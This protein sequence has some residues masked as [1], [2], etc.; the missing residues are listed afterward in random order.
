MS[1]NPFDPSLS[2]EE[3]TELWEPKKEYIEKD[4]WVIRNFLTEQELV[5]LNNEANDP[6]G[7]Y[8]TMRSPYGG[9]IKNKFIGYIPEYDENGSLLVPNEK[10]KWKNRDIMSLIEKRIE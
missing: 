5:Y 1:K 8:T 10:S 6:E 2:L 4:L 9:N 7:W 3:L